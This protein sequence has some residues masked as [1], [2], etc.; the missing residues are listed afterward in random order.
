MGN[1]KPSLD[2]IFYK[3]LSENAIFSTLT[4][5]DDSIKEIDCTL[6]PPTNAS[7]INSSS[8]FSRADYEMARPL[9]AG[10]NSM[11]E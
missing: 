11:I 7:V 2:F 4:L 3:Y 10:Y 8:V 9:E 5:C 6:D 1:T